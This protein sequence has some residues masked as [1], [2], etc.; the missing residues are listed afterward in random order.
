MNFCLRWKIITKIR[1]GISSYTISEANYPYYPKSKRQLSSE[2]ASFKQYTELKPEHHLARLALAKN[3][4]ELSFF[5]QSARVL[6]P[7]VI[8]E[9]FR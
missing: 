2:I 9:T 6:E 1:K 5:R 3:Y 8:L 4:H 7:L